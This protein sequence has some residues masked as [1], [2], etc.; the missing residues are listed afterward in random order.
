MD[1]RVKAA[2]ARSVSK[3]RV[4]R[5]KKQVSH[6][7]FIKFSHLN[8]FK[9]SKIVFDLFKKLNFQILQKIYNSKKMFVKKSQFSSLCTTITPQKFERITCTQSLACCCHLAS[10]WVAPLFLYIIILYSYVKNKA[11]K[12]AGEGCFQFYLY[13]HYIVN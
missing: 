9:N 4:K 7:F 10:F 6:R 5:K 3:N 13:C 1:K 8:N 12:T 2:A 11:F